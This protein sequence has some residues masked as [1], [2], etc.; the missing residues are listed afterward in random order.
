VLLL[1]RLHGQLAG[2]QALDGVGRWVGSGAIMVD[3][4]LPPLPFSSSARTDTG[5]AA[6]SGSSG[7]ASWS[8]N[9][10]RSAPVDSAITTSF[11][12]QPAAFFTALT[13]SSGTVQ[14][15]QRRCGPTAG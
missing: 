2:A 8:I 11:T 6:T 9:Q 15:A 14:N 13:S 5:T 10:V 4:R 7:R 1:G 3:T 12:V